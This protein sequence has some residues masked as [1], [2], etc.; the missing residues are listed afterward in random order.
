MAYSGRLQEG[1]C[2]GG[3][4]IWLS[5]R[6]S[7]KGRLCG[8]PEQPCGKPFWECARGK[9]ERDAGC[10]FQGPG[11][12]VWRC[13]CTGRS[14]GFFGAQT[15]ANDLEKRFRD[16]PSHSSSSQRFARVSLSTM[17]SLHR[18]SKC[19]KCRAL[20]L[21]VRQAALLRCSALFFRSICVARPISP[22]TKAPRRPWNSRKFIIARSLS[23]IQ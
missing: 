20:D 14:G 10:A 21:G 18:L 6:P 9:A 22:R 7:G 8:N 19:Y 12:G 3:Q 16:T 23:A 17:A 1:G 13:L 5:S 2:H 4:W 15:L 11:R